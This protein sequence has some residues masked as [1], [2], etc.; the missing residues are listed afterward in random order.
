MHLGLSIIFQFEKEI[1]LVSSKNPGFF[2]IFL[3]F[4]SLYKY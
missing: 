4:L 1:S 3:N 2:F